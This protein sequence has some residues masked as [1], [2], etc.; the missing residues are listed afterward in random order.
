MK[1]G[2]STDSVLFEEKADEI[3]VLLREFADLG[4]EALFE[5]GKRFKICVICQLP[6][7]DA[8][9]LERGMGDACFK[10]LSKK[11]YS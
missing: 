6:L 5:W 3:L 7:T 2:T 9:S 1:I 8:Q 4:T 11:M 10:K